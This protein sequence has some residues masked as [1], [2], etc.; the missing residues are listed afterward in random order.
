MRR[1]DLE[2]IA[3]PD[4]LLRL[5]D[6]R[7]I[8]GLAHVRHRLRGGMIGDPVGGMDKAGVEVR[9]GGGKTLPRGL[10][11]L[12]G[13]FF[14]RRP[15]RRD[16]VEPIENG[17]ENRDDRR[18]DQ[19]TIGNAQQIGI[20]IGQTLDLPD[21]AIAQIPEQPARHRRQGSRD[22]D[23]AFVQQLAQAV[24]RSCCQHLERIR[25]GRGLSVDRRLAP[26]AAPHEVGLQPY[27][28]VP[29]PIGTAFHGLE[30][31]AQRLA[32]RNLEECRHR[33]VEIGDQACPDERRFFPAKSGGESFEVGLTG[34]GRRSVST[35]RGSS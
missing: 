8:I 11:G 33:R 28:R 2:D 3:G 9:D 26:I 25:V 21:H 35:E 12:L 7:V 10:P 1:H 13:R 31:E 17:V 34:H 22:R 24:E 29:P 27:N 18:S 20:R 32:I 23:P 14:G 19:H 30:Q 15:H 5:L 16:D 6:H 4:I